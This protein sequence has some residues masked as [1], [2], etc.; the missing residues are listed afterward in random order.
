MS[1]ENVNCH[2]NQ[3]KLA[4]AIKN[5]VFVEANAMDIAAKFQLYRLYLLLRN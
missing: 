2:C 4:T 1:M 5:D 3:N